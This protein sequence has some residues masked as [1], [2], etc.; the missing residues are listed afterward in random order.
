MT[1][2]DDFT[3]EGNELEHIRHV[4]EYQTRNLKK[5]LTWSAMG[6]LSVI[7]IVLLIMLAKRNA[8]QNERTVVVPYRELQAP[9]SL[10]QTPP[11]VSVAAPAAQPTAGI[12]LPT[13][14]EQ[15]QEEQTIATQEE[16][17]QSIGSGETGGN[18]D[19]LVI[20]PPSDALPA[21]GE[22]VY[23]EELL[24]G[25][26][27]GAARVPGHRPPA[28]SMEG[29][30]V[31]QALVGKDGKVKD[32]K[33]VKS[34]P[35]LDDAAVAAVEVGLQA[36]AVEQQ[37]GRRV[38]RGACSDPRGTCG[39]PR[40]PPARRASSPTGCGTPAPR[41]A[42]PPGRPGPCPDRA[43]RTSTGIRGGPATNSRPVTSLE[44][45]GHPLL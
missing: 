14:D 33:V 17:S 29:T 25:D 35:V 5:A 24:R 44:L 41:G 15:V 31:V 39:T 32:T 21:F 4:R 9:P 37:A 26:F 30:V 11:T 18:G 42:A 36:R 6:H 22:Y 43:S 1:L 45:N 3:L 10:Q 38:G 2:P 34:V 20:A 16:L 23:V 27:E 8:P 28:S 12:P 13:E 7:V 40:S 19:S